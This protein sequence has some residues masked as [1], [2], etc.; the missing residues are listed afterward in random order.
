MNKNFW[1]KDGEPKPELKI[2]LVMDDYKLKNKEE[3][4]SRGIGH[5]SK[6]FERLYRLDREEIGPGITIN[7]VTLIRFYKLRYTP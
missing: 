2:A 7:T 4:W 6:E 5:L 1:L 3:W